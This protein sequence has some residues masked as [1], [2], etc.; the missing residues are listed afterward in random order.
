M[1]RHDDI[2]SP[3]D[4]SRAQVQ[5]SREAFYS[6]EN[7]A[8]RLQMMDALTDVILRHSSLSDL[9]EKLIEHVQV[10]MNVDN[11][12]ILRLH[13][14]KQAL[15]MYTVRGPEEVVASRVFVP[16]GQGIAGKIFSTRQ[17]LIV[18]DLAKVDVVNAFLHEH[19]HSLLGVPLHVEDQMIGVIHI[20]TVHERLFT[21]E[22]VQV[23]Q[24]VADRIAIAIERA[25]NFEKLQQAYAE[26]EERASELEA[27]N[28]RM[29]NFISI[30]SH[31]MRTP[32]TTIIASLDLFQRRIERIEHDPAQI[33]LRD[34]LTTVMPLAKRA[35]TQA[36]RLNR[37]ISDL[38]DSARIQADQLE[39]HL[40]SCD[41]RDIV[42]EAVE[43]QRLMLPDRDIRL[44][45]PAHPMW[46]EADA[47]RIG[48]VVTNYLTNALKFSPERSSIQIKLENKHEN[49]YVAVTDHGPG[50]QEKDQQRIWERFHRVEA[51]EHQQGSYIGLGLGLYI[52]KTIIER[53]HG[54]IG[55]RSRVDQGSTFWFTLP[56]SEP[57]SA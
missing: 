6:N 10:I 19:L 22:D 30:A 27:L 31:E 2:A 18:D 45:I 26:A 49:A 13:P 8:M 54:R 23:L 33:T 16:V 57:A 7:T 50:I 14:E 12:A 28:R 56:Q 51:I 34:V 1:A 47:D 17:P 25:H 20:S 9:V 11:V 15:I 24:V 53:H 35:R 40:S 37:L 46:V 55:I 48:Q 52:C 5:E 41:L 21:N 44:H 39:I 32:L 4:N 29:D 3:D 42:R 36:G 38:L 43:E